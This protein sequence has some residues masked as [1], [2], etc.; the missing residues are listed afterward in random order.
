MQTETLYSK[1][2]PAFKGFDVTFTAEIERDAYD[3]GQPEIDK[4]VNGKIDAGHY[5]HFVAVITLSISGIALGTS[6]LG[7]CCHEEYDGFLTSGYLPQ[8]LEEAHGVA[9]E[10]SKAIAMGV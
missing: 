4:E 7:S 6:A 8:M 3:T 5:V 9:L 2:L 10:K 1:T